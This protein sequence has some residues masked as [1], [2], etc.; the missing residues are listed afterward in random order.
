MFGDSPIED[1]IYYL[2]DNEFGLKLSDKQVSIAFIR[3]LR[4]FNMH[5]KF[6]HRMA[7][8]ILNRILVRRYSAGDFTNDSKKVRYGVGDLSEDFDYET[9]ASSK[10]G[11]ELL[12][13]ECKWREEDTMEFI[14]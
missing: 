10:E 11:K 9:W 5:C 4:T 12:E 6:D 14:Q 3:P 7:N 2:E 8:H 13:L 1:D